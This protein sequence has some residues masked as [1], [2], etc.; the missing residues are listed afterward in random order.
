MA[1]NWQKKIDKSQ[2]KKNGEKIGN[3]K[4]AKKKIGK[5]KKKKTGKKFG[6]KICQLPHFRN[7]VGLYFGQVG[8]LPQRISK[9]QYYA[10]FFK[11]GSKSRLFGKKQ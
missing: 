4:L 10:T 5:R 6:T 9:S 1:K 8:E 3:Q 2:K 7:L 11:N